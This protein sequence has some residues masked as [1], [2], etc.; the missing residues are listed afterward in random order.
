M[1]THVYT[2][3]DLRLFRCRKHDQACMPADWK[4]F[5]V[6]CLPVGKHL[7]SSFPALIRTSVFPVRM[8][9]QLHC[10]SMAM[11]T[12]TKLKVLVLVEHA[13]RMTEKQ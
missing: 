8:T 12:Q 3:S 9:E 5:R 1:R 11:H 7:T 13:Q 2:L 6:L 10:W 4:G